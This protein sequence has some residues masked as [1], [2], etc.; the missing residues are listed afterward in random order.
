M[1]AN[2]EIFHYWDQVESL[3]EVSVRALAL[4]AE[5]IRAD[6]R[7]SMVATYFLTQ[8]LL[9]FVPVKL[10]GKRNMWIFYELICYHG[11]LSN[12]I[13]ADGMV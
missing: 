7:C 4:L 3:H 6:G 5:P 8:E 10:S 12:M 9:M 13:L 1:S 11:F 2:D